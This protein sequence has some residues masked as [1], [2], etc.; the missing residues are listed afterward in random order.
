MGKAYGIAAKHNQSYDT[1]TNITRTDDGDPY[2]VAASGNHH[3]SA[4][5]KILKMDGGRVV[6]AMGNHHFDSWDILGEFNGT[7][8]E[9]GGRLAA[10]TDLWKGNSIATIDGDYVKATRHTPG[11]RRGDR[12][13]KVEAQVAP[14]DYLGLALGALLSGVL[15]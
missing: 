14:N 7:T 1:W 15:Y 11:Y 8:L 2:I 13:I 5:D 6:A 10:E 12:I 4:W 3:Y 9:V